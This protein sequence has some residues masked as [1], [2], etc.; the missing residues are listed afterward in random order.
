MITKDKLLH[1]GVGAAMG[2]LGL[3]LPLSFPIV[4]SILAAVGKDLYD[5][6]VKKTE[7]DMEDIYFTLGGTL[8]T[9]IPLG[10]VG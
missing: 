7:F 9:A 6:K 3:F 10:M 5:L 1:A 8:L 4:L 2:L